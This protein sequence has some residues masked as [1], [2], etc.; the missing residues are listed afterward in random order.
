[1][2]SDSNLILIW[3]HLYLPLMD[4]SHD[5]KVAVWLKLQPFL[6]LFFVFKRQYL[7]LSASLECR[8]ERNLS[9]PMSYRYPYKGIAWSCSEMVGGIIY[10]FQ[11]KTWQVPNILWRCMQTLVYSGYNLLT[12]HSRLSLAKLLKVN[13]SKA[14][15]W[16]S[17]SHSIRNMHRL[18]LRWK[19]TKAKLGH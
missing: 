2:I 5:L 11:I 16:L 17:F 7:R 4:H 6:S 14:T 12:E 18:Y 15:S 1:M 3:V 10:F 13:R 8:M 19:K 9:I